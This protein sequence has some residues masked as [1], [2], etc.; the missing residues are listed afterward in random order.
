MD[1]FQSSGSEVKLDYTIVAD[2]LVLYSY[3]LPEHTSVSGFKHKI[4]VEI[5]RRHVANACCVVLVLSFFWNSAVLI[6]SYL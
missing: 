2:D 5:N 6:G 3:E 4:D 1:N